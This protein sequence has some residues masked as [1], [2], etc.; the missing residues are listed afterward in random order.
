MKRL[1]AI[2]ASAAF[3]A[4]LATAAVLADNNNDSDKIYWIK[5]AVQ[6][7]TGGQYV[8]DY[9]WDDY[10]LSHSECVATTVQPSG[11][12]SE[13]SYKIT[14]YVVCPFC[15]ELIEFDDATMPHDAIYEHDIDAH[16]YSEERSL[17]NELDDEF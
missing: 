17:C 4:V 10:A 14:N 5:L 6:D 13:P 7:V 15:H 11:D 3:V 1:V 9:Y 8:I 12:T 16:G 2:I